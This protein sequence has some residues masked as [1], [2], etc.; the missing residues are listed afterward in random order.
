MYILQCFSYSVFSSA[1]SHKLMFFPNVTS[2]SPYLHAIPWSNSVGFRIPHLCF[3]AKFIRKEE[4][5]YFT[6]ASFSFCQLTHSITFPLP[7]IT[8][9]T[10]AGGYT[11]HFEEHQYM[12]GNGQSFPSL[13]EIDKV[14]SLQRNAEKDR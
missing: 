14:L 12:N 3:P 2:V 10:N 11:W 6:N 8:V 4:N 7:T 5:V 1:F 13:G 9:F